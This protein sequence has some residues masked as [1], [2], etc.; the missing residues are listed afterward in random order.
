M[1]LK[2]YIAYLSDLY[3]NFNVLNKILQGK[4]LNLV[5]VKV[6]L[7]IFRN[8]LKLLETNFLNN[9]FF[10]FSS[11]EKLTLQLSEDEVLGYSS[12][13]KGHRCDV[14]RKFEDVVQINVSIWI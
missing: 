8:K 11:L 5:K 1:T 10:Q 9:Q 2:N 3:A 6:K 7:I 12:H 4:T 14:D 13:V